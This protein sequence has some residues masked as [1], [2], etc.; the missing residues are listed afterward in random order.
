MIQ[1]E[2]KRLAV[3]VSTGT[4]NGKTFL[5]VRDWGPGITPEVRSRM[6]E[7]F[8][9]TKPVGKGTGLGL[10]IISRI[11]EQHGGTLE[12]ENCPDGGTRFVLTI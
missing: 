6:F 12:A 9:T 7:P 4:R 3:K 10:Y 1:G 5:E 11:A 2:S 8:F